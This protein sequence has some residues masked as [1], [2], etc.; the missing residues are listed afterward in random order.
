[1]RTPPA[2]D[3]ATTLQLQRASGNAQ[4]TQLIARTRDEELLGGQYAEEAGE[5][6]G[7]VKS[8]STKYWETVQG[9]FSKD[10][11]E[12]QAKKDAQGPAS[13]DDVA[14][15]S[16]RA[17]EYAEEALLVAA[18]ATRALGTKQDDPYKTNDLTEA[19]DNFEGA[20]KHVGTAN[21]AF[22][23]G[24][25]KLKLYFA[26]R[27][28]M[29][30]AQ[31][32]DKAKTPQEAAKAFDEMFAATGA[33]ADFLP[34]EGPHKAYFEFLAAFDTNGGFFTNMVTAIGLEKPAYNQRHQV[35]GWPSAAPSAWER[36]HGQ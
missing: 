10:A 25:K 31:A 30:A 18:A 27:R 21:K 4:V 5:K 11:R 15:D 16:T 2:L 12:E 9:W 6:L 17:A 20:A 29:S 7:K 23:W 19:A 22:S 8:H 26:V 35:E 1:V 3:V 32:L 36:V 28:V 14:E 34:G 33:L 13:I 24:M